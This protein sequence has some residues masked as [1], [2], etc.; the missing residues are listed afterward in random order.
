MKQRRSV[1][2]HIQALSTM[3]VDMS[4]SETYR[5][6]GDNACSFFN[7]PEPSKAIAEAL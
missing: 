6:M 7:L 5:L 2:P 1:D 3:C 4:Q